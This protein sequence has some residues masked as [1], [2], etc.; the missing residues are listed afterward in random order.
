MLTP[1]LQC[2]LDVRGFDFGRFQFTRSEM[3]TYEFANGT[4]GSNLRIEVPLVIK[5]SQ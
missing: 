4:H 1:T 3:Y 5:H 2:L